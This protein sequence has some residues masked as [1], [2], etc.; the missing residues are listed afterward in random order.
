[1]LCDNVHLNQKPNSFWF[2]R[3]KTNRNDNCGWAFHPWLVSPTPIDNH[4]VHRVEGR[5]KQKIRIEIIYTHYRGK[6]TTCGIIIYPAFA[7]LKVFT[8]IN[9]KQSSTTIHVEYE[10]ITYAYWCSVRPMG[11]RRL[12]ISNPFLCR[13]RKIP[14]VW[15]GF[16]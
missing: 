7:R 12:R 4:P 16:R 15:F 11:C 13:K 2:L 10:S 3:E 1:M 6:S 5:R 8:M 14:F 9:V